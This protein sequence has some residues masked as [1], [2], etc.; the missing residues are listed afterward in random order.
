[1]SQNG[2]GID[3]LLIKVPLE[4]E[5][6]ELEGEEESG[7]KEKRTR[8][9]EARPP[10]AGICGRGPRAAEGLSG[11]GNWLVDTSWPTRFCREDKSH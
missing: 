4:C 8:G 9:L 2:Y 10:S 7:E 1:M 6:K 3:T 5:G 11:L